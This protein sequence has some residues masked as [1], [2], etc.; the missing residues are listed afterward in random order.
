MNKTEIVHQVHK[1]LESKVP[2]KTIDEVVDTL[3]DVITESLRQGQDVQ[4]GDFGTLSLTKFAVK[5]AEKFISK[6]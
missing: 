4:L 2:L 6:K 3:L 1:N 5:P